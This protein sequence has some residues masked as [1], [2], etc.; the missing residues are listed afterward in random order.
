MLLLR[1]EA[2]SRSKSWSALLRKRE[3]MPYVFRVN[4]ARPSCR[5]TAMCICSKHS[6]KDSPSLFQFSPCKG[7]SQCRWHAK[8]IPIETVKS[9]H[10]AQ[11][12][13]VSYAYGRPREKQVFCL[14]KGYEGPCLRVL[15]RYE[16]IP[17]SLSLSTLTCQALS[18]RSPS[19]CLPQC[20]PVIDGKRYRGTR[21][22]WCCQWLPKPIWHIADT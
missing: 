10:V 12:Y 7:R 2:L 22:T 18:N 1:Q 15:D 14:V 16:S 5:Y 19:S 21:Q 20:T 11:S 13:G 3:S 17:M 9:Y 4:Q 8:G 6:P